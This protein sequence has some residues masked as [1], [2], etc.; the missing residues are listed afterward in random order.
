M[1]AHSTSAWRFIF[2]G[3]S[4][5]D[6][7]LL[8]RRD[9][10]SIDGGLDAVCIYTLISTVLNT[11]PVLW[12]AAI[13]DSRDKSFGETFSKCFVYSSSPPGML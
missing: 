1:S 9:H 8:P 6:A 2:L 5:P 7:I 13:L 12:K 3:Y 10:N 4:S 11:T